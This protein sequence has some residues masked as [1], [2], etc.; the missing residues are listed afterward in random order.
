ME[1]VLMV[2]ADVHKKS[3]RVRYGVGQAKPVGKS[4]GGRKKG[5]ERL[6]TDMWREARRVGAS[7]IVMAYEASSVGYVMRD[8]AMDAGIE[9]HVLAPTKIKKSGQ[10]HKKK[11][12]DKDAIRIHEVVKNHILAGSAIPAV[13]VADEETRDAREVVRC[14]TDWGQKLTVVKCEIQSLLMRHGLEKP[15][16]YE[17]NWTKKHRRWIASWAEGA[18]PLG[19][20]GRQALRS[21]LRQLAF[22][23]E[24]AQVLDQAV[25]KKAE[26][27]RYRKAVAALDAMT[28]IRVL[29]AMVF[30]TE[31][32]DMKRFKNRRQVGSIMGLAP[33]SNESGDVKDRK[34]HITRFG[35]SRLRRSLCQAVWSR[36]KQEG[37]VDRVF[38]DRLVNRN[39][40]KKMIAVVA[41]MRKLGVKMWH[42][43]SQASA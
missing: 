26:R 34:G 31:L 30:L 20:G 3:I 13:W 1:K 21:L 38:Y 17:S 27:P 35:S 29:T 39:P 19:E 37:G 36:I 5:R 12:D 42:V 9:C 33:S 28:G 7:R 18:S 23:E 4:W 32:G 2:G 43:A 6:M 8:E 15:E 41:C 11:T 10:D 40:K 16:G 25:I 22:L 24:E 14:R